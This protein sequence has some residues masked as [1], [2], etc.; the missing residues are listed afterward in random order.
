MIRAKDGYD[1]LNPS[2]NPIYKIGGSRIMHQLVIQLAVQSKDDPTMPWIT[3]FFAK[4]WIRPEA[5]MKSIAR[6]RSGSAKFLNLVVF[7]KELTLEEELHCC[8]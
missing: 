6:S 7:T 4:Y 5:T 1:W 8:L 2:D 3:E